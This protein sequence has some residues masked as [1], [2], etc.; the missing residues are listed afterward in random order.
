MESALIELHRELS[1]DGAGRFATSKQRIL[2][3]CINALQVGLIPRQHPLG[4]FITDLSRLLPRSRRESE[5]RLHVWPEDYR[6]RSDNRGEIHTHR[7]DLRSA[8]IRGTIRNVTYELVHDASAPGMVR[9]VV[10]R[11]RGT[12]LIT[13]AKGVIARVANV[14]EVAS[15]HLYSESAEKFHSSN[16]VSAPAITIVLGIPRGA[17]ARVFVDVASQARGEEEFIRT[18]I[19][20]AGVIEILKTTLEET[21]S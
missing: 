7:F 10:Y 15:G 14:F 6:E 8:V 5:F 13:S 1:Q 16:L 21:P 19:E 11:P 2:R 17:S 4:F 18:P 9:D 20:A 3:E 12:T